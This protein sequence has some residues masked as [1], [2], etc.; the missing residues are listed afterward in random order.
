[1]ASTGVWPPGGSHRAKHLDVAEVCRFRENCGQYCN[2]EWPRKS[3]PSYSPSDELIDGQ[4][5]EQNREVGNR[6]ME[7]LDRLFRLLFRTDGGT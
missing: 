3:K 7:V 5:R 2:R 6:E 1:M 4:G